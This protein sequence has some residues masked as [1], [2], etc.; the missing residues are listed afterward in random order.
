MIIGKKTLK[1]EKASYPLWV[2][3]YVLAGASFYPILKEGSQLLKP[4]LLFSLGAVGFLEGAAMDFSRLRGKLKLGKSAVYFLPTLIVFFL[5]S[6]LVIEIPSTCLLYSI[7]ISLVSLY[8]I[9]GEKRIMVGLWELM[10]IP[11]IALAFSLARGHAFLSFFYHLLLAI[12]FGI[13]TYLVM[14]IRASE[15]EKIALLIGIIL[16]S[17]GTASYFLLSPI[18]VGFGAGVIY[19][20]LPDIA[21]VERF[22]PKLISLERPVF[23]FLLL[24]L[25]LN[26]PPALSL[27][28]LALAL[29]FFATKSLYGFLIKE[30]GFLSLSP[31][32]AAMV[33]SFFAHFPRI[34]TPALFSAFAL[35]FL[36][37]ETEEFLLGV[38]GKGEKNYARR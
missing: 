15:G 16:F 8:G 35:L 34:T 26:L 9:A 23:I 17:S 7:S 13:T 29:L 33:I 6:C 30:R 36:L 4:F 32:S 31:L 22:V 1:M 3:F 12:I 28:S 27:N 38:K 5:L 18:F 21:G 37:L 10:A 20:N 14:G 24:Y 11:F 2:I 19:A 25:G